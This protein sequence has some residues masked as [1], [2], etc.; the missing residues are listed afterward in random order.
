MAKIKLNKNENKK[1]E[2]KIPCQELPDNHKLK[3]HSNEDD[4]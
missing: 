2:T 1:F 4:D 3:A